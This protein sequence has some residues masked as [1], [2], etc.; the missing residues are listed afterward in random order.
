MLVTH[1][2]EHIAHIAGTRERLPHTFAVD[3]SVP[4]KG[5]LLHAAVRQN[6]G[7]GY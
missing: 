5:E 7:D 4:E 3:G 2:G 1:S 6:G